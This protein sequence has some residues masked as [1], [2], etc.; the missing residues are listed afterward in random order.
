MGSHPPRC[1][2]EVAPDV[3]D[4]FG[5]SEATVSSCGRCVERAFGAFDIAE[6]GFGFSASLSGRPS[7]G[8]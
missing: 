6:S 3:I 4:A 1:E 2:H 5:P 8:F 7:A